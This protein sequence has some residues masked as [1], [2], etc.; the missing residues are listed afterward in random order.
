MEELDLSR[1]A[2]L[3]TEGPVREWY[4]RARAAVDEGLEGVGRAVR[5][6]AEAAG[7][8]GRGLGQA[9]QQLVRAGGSFS[10]AVGDLRRA[11]QSG[12]NRSTPSGSKP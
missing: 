5:A 6:G 3:E 11:I 7:R 1:E 4:D 12:S 9:G 8:A 10:Q 2:G